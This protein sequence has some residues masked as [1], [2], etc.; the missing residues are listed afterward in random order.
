MNKILETI[1][2]IVVSLG[3]ASALLLALSGW[4]GKI[5]AKHIANKEVAEYNKQLEKLKGQ[6]NVELSKLSRANDII[7]KINIYQFEKE[8]ERYSEIW[9]NLFEIIL[10]TKNLFPQ[11]GQYTK[12]EEKQYKEDVYIE[13][14]EAYNRFSK[15]IEKH[16]PFYTEEIFKDLSEIREVCLKQGCNYQV[17]ELDFFKVND[18]SDVD[19]EDDIKRRR[20][21]EMDAKIRKEVYEIN[22]A[23]LKE[24]NDRVTIK[25][26]KYL[27]LKKNEFKY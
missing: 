8:Y 19:N 2:H 5:F 13:Y 22:P 21:G 27:T 11:M 15:N 3:G 20:Q 14:S 17:F 23:K 10:K 26:R 16:A 12:K 24:L 9:D 25:L 1:G 6:L 18:A 7:S 4:L